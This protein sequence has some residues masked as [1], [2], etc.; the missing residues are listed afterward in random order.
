MLGSEDLIFQGL[1][2]G[3][4]RGGH[5]VRLQLKTCLMET[6]RERNQMREKGTSAVTYSK[7]RTSFEWP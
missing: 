7:C 1:R 2:E 6:L 4:G 3:E 5:W